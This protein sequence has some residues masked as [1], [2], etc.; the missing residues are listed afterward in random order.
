MYTY[1]SAV[2]IAR[3]GRIACAP[4]TPPLF[5]LE[6]AGVRSAL[7]THPYLPPGLGRKEPA[8]YYDPRRQ[9]VQSHI[10]SLGGGASSQLHTAV[11][12]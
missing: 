7:A 9:M 11:T 3:R 10:L 4:C 6:V 1:R 12:R 2:H 8:A 5:G